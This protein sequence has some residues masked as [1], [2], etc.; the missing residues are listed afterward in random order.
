[1]YYINYRGGLKM[2]LCSLCQKIE[3]IRVFQARPYYN[4]L[5]DE[6]KRKV[7]ERNKKKY[8]FNHIL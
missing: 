7:V 1:M 8:L 6:C 4:D 5:C 3:K 2:D